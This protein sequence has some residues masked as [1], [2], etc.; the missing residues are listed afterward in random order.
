MADDGP[1][2]RI[3]V[4]DTHADRLGDL[5][6]DQVGPLAVIRTVLKLAGERP[7][8][9]HRLPGLKEIYLS[10]ERLPTSVNAKRAKLLAKSIGH[11]PWQP[12]PT[13]EEWVRKDR[14]PRQRSQDPDQE[15][16]LPKRGD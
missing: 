16:G 1:Y 10:L 13:D 5:E 7:D 12:S 3:L 11:D 8:G 2:H 14:D 6:Q 4:D 9:T 15:V